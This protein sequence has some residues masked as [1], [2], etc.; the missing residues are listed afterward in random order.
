MLQ[1]QGYTLKEIQCNF[2]GSN[3]SSVD[4]KGIVSEF[5]IF[6]SIDSPAVRGEFLITDANDFISNLRGFEEIKLSLS[7]DSEPHKPYELVQRIYKIGANVKSERTQ[8]Y[9]IHTVSEFALLNEKVKVFKTFKGTASDT[10]ERMLKNRLKVSKK[11]EIEPTKGAFPFISPSWRPFDVI[12]YLTDPSIRSSSKGSSVKEQQSGFLFFE[13]RDA[14]HFYSIDGLIEKAAK[15]QSKISAKNSNTK[16][17]KKFIY[18][19]KNVGGAEDGYFTIENITYPDKYDIVT[20]MRSGALGTSLYGIDPGSINESYLPKSSKTSTSSD[21]DPKGPGGG[22]YTVVQ[23][24]ADKSWQSRFSHLPG[25]ANPYSDYGGLGGG[26]GERMRI[27]FFN[28]Y[29]FDSSEGGGVTGTAQAA[30][31]ANKGSTLQ[32]G[33]S[34]KAGAAAN[35]ENITVAALYSL[36][37]YTA[38]NIVKLNIV[39]P[40]NVGVTAGDVIDVE[41]PSSKEQGN[42]VPKEKTYSGQYL[43]MGVVHIWRPEGVSTHLQIGRDS[44]SKD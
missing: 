3:Q 19:Q 13:N 6:E 28:T 1:S 14:V 43:I 33:T 2:S 36:M 21:S 8:Q 34:N 40:G 25:S 4:I 12:S 26:E 10:V 17:V 35:P 9:I 44:I 30:D 11:L 37:R 18:R 39:I 32:T 42:T 15:S 22:N 38:L 5:S 7:T 27:K 29:G 16:N 20:Q 41:I 23:M 31:Q 24:S